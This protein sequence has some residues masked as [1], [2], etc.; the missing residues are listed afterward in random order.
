MIPSGVASGGRRRL[1]N[2]WHINDDPAVGNG[3]T[4]YAAATFDLSG[5][6]LL[7]TFPAIDDY[8]VVSERQPACREP[9]QGRL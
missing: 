7:L 3:I 1:F 5:G 9:E 2:T 4:A 8:W 6:P